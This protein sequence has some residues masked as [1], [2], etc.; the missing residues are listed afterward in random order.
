MFDALSPADRELDLLTLS[1]QVF[2][3]LL[4]AGLVLVTPRRY[5]ELTRWIAVTFAAALLTLGLCRFID[6]YTILD[7]YSDRTVTSLYHPAATL[8]ARSDQQSSDA[9]QPVPRPY[10]SDDLL[11]RRP[12]AARLDLDYALGVDGPGLAVTLL[13]AL[14]TLTAG[15]ASFRHD[16]RLRQ[17][18]ALAFVLQTAVTGAA[19]AL[20]LALMTAFLGLGVVAVALLL[21]PA[22]ALG[23]RFAVTSLAGGVAFVAAV[24]TLHIADV[25]DFVDPGVHAAR[26]AAARQADPRLTPNDAIDRTPVRSF[27]P[28]TLSKFQRAAGLVAR[29]RA[30]RVTA[31]RANAELPR[32][33]DDPNFVPLYAPATDPDAAAARLAARPAAGRPT[34]ATIFVLLAVAAACGLGL[35]PANGWLADALTRLP[36]PA[37]IALVGAAWPLAGM[38]TIRLLLML[39]SGVP[40]LWRPL[41]GG[42]GLASLAAG[43]VAS[44]RTSDLARLAAAQ[45]TTTGGLALIGL[46]AWGDAPEAWEQGV[47][48]AALVV[49]GSTVPAVM[50][51]WLAAAMR[52]RLGHAD[53][54]LAGPLWNRAPGLAAVTVSALLLGAAIPG[55]ALFIGALAAL[56]AGL[57]AGVLIGAFAVL[58]ALAHAAH[59][60]ALAGQLATGRATDTRT[61]PD[62]VVGE[63]LPLTGLAILTVTLGVAPSLVL[64]WLD[65]SIQGLVSGAVPMK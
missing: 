5:P 61:V 59:R 20:D 35:F 26:A 3:P 32:P 37:A 31:R 43:V 58:L 42:L 65:P 57:H 19:L 29:G 30:D 15:I 55:G 14:A 63:W 21:G 36:A 23:L 2:G 24:L 46:G 1:V 34:R 13:A 52:D 9:A 50:L 11:V 4:A 47:A 62:L 6:Y 25:R 49:I 41:L 38:L 8:D 56:S 10:R 33:G 53:L 40:D 39:A 7:S 54:S 17:T 27:D 16:A 45:L 18:L 64:V 48:G 60:L 51:V 44:L 22:G 28:V 12:W